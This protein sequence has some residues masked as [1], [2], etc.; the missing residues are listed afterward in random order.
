MLSKKRSVGLRESANHIAGSTPPLSHQDRAP[1]PQALPT[2]LCF[3]L[4]RPLLIHCDPA[5]AVGQDLGSDRSVH[6]AWPRVLRHIPE[7]T[8]WASADASCNHSLGRGQGGRARPTGSPQLW[9]LATE[10]GAERVGMQGTVPQGSVGLHCRGGAVWPQGCLA[11]PSDP[12]AAWPPALGLSLSCCACSS[13][14]N[15]SLDLTGPMPRRA[16]LCPKRP[17]TAPTA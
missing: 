15:Q 11:K 17:P 8:Q 5:P 10:K 4:R 6:W 13:E 16:H 9:G 3:C 2:G 1:C 12:P 14:A 7:Q